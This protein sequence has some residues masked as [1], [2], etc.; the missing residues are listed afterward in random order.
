M[1]TLNEALDRGIEMA[2]HCGTQRM[3]DV[4]K[5]MKESDKPGV[6]DKTVNNELNWIKESLSAQRCLIDQFRCELDEL[7]AKT[8][9]KGIKPGGYGTLALHIEEANKRIAFLE[10]DRGHRLNEIEKSLSD[11]LSHYTKTIAEMQNTSADKPKHIYGLG[12]EAVPHNTCPDCGNTDCICKNIFGTEDPEKDH[13]YTGAVTQEGTRWCD[14]CN[15]WH[16]VIISPIYHADCQCEKCRNKEVINK[17]IIEKLDLLRRILL[18]HDHKFAITGGGT[19]SS[20]YEAIRII[21]EIKKQ[22]EKTE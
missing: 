3:I 13:C 15:S 4:L 8:H 7:K 9:V 1:T 14:S 10:K 5:A 20:F 11:H 19:Y 16:K 12:D 18:A 6:I 2:R 17:G 22:L 21:D